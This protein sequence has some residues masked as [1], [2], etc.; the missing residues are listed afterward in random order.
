LNLRISPL[1]RLVARNKS[2]NPACTPVPVPLRGRY[3]CDSKPGGPLSQDTHT[4]SG[5]SFY[6]LGVGT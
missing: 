6:G 4:S 2:K 1:K 3:S 5:L